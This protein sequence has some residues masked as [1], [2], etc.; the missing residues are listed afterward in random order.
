MVPVP[1][2]TRHSCPRIDG[3]FRWLFWASGSYAAKVTPTCS[4][5]VIMEAAVN[6]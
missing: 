3:G 6:S 2:H 5:L 4:P 1:A